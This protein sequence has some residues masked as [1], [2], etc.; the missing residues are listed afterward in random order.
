MCICSAPA[1]PRS[2]HRPFLS[3]PR[4]PSPT[5]AGTNRY[6]MT[7]YMYVYIYIYICNMCIYIC[8][9]TY[10]Y[11]YIYIYAYGSAYSQSI[12]WDS[13]ETALSRFPTPTVPHTVHNLFRWHRQNS[14]TG[15]LSYPTPPVPKK[16]LDISM[17]RMFKVRSSKVRRDVLLYTKALKH[18]TILF[19]PWF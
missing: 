7:V 5:E 10:I 3:A 9:Y 17:Q 19:V 11:I 14:R 12:C 2:A 13:L 8:I 15:V 6:S 16:W 4:P 18:R 1:Q